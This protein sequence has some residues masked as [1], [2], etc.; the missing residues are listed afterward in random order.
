MQQVLA[1]PGLDC[2]GEALPVDPFPEAGKDPAPWLSLDHVP[3]LCF[4]A[5]RRR[6][7]GGRTIIRMHLHREN[8]VGIKKL[9]KQRKRR[10]LAAAAKKFSW[11]LA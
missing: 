2:I 5:V 3:G 11:M 8:L 10:W 7:S 9:E 4:A 6:S 1:P